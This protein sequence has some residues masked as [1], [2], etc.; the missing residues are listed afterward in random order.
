MLT[1]QQLTQTMKN[2]ILHQYNSTLGSVEH[3][4]HTYS[5]SNSKSLKYSIKSALIDLLNLDR[6][7]HFKSFEALCNLDS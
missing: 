4:S 6:L 2:M 3:Q 7:L 5:L 1:F